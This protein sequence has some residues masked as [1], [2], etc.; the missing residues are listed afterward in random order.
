[1]GDLKVSSSNNYLNIF[2]KKREAEITK[3]L[4]KNALS[5]DHPYIRS[6]RNTL[7]E[8]NVSKGI[9]QTLK[10][11]YDF[12]YA[13]NP[14]TEKREL[15]FVPA[16]FENFLGYC[17][18]SSYVNDQGGISFNSNR[19][20]LANKVGTNL[21]KHASRKLDYQFT[22]IRSSHLNAWALP[23]GKIAIFEGLVKGIEKTEINGFKDLTREDKIAAVLSHEIVHADARHTARRLEKI[24]VINILLVALR[25]YLFAK[26]VIGIKESKN[27]K[28]NKLEAY[29]E[30]DFLANYLLNLCVKLYLLATSRKQELEADR[31]GM[32]LMKKAGYNPKAAVWLQK[33]FISRQLESPRWAV[34]INEILSSHPSSKARLDANLKTLNEIESRS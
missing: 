24:F 31:Y 28:F 6:D 32:Y 8:T 13:K 26:I 5:D 23:W 20:N 4:N 30:I 27:D 25:I 21:S 29:Q 17:M 2:S 12:I 10:K 16:F 22:V 19:Q 11:S 3:T 33:F 1:M 9:F 18:Y 7:K 15:W 34:K 14:V